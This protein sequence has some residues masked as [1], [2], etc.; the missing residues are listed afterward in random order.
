MKKAVGE[1]P[2]RP[3]H[4]FVSAYWKGAFVKELPDAAIATHVEHGSQVPELTCTM[5]L[6]PINGA[7]NRVGPDNTAFAY[8]D[9][10]YAMVLLAG[11]TDPAKDTERIGWLR[12]YYDALSCTY[13]GHFGVPEP[14]DVVRV[15]RDQFRILAD[16]IV[17]DELGGTLAI[18]PIENLRDWLAEFE[19]ARA[20]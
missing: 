6:Y 5:H 2:E 15:N 1:K 20:Q 10:T 8:R 14:A 4:R 9:C 19:L 12:G 3:R 7:V 11:W 17:F 16:S 18:P 13:R